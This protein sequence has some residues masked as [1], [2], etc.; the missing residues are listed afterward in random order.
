MTSAASIYRNAQQQAISLS[1]SA[2]RPTFLNKNFLSLVA[3][4]DP[5]LNL[6]NMAYRH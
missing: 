1:G 3:Y 2:F 5:K 4:S 6:L